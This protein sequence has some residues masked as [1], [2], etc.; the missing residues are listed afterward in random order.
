[1]W[2]SVFDWII[3]SIFLFFFDWHNTNRLH[4][5][6]FAR[7][8]WCRRNFE[9][10][11]VVYF[12]RSR[13]FRLVDSRF[14][15]V[16][17]FSSGWKPVMS[18]DIPW[19]LPSPDDALFIIWQHVGHALKSSIKTNFYFKDETNKPAF[20]FG[21][22]LDFYKHP[23][24]DMKRNERNRR[25]RKIEQTKKNSWK[26]CQE[27]ATTTKWWTCSTIGI[28]IS[29]TTTTT[30]TTHTAYRQRSTCLLTHTE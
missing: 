19:M 26:P 13:L 25:R 10:L 30:R 11:L 18:K 9:C 8:L 7:Y 23:M 29:S 28:S 21:N 2:W 3:S 17:L 20:S 6:H 5:T 1:M 12:S 14:L 16:Y 4:G 27:S 22:Y 15:S 24:S